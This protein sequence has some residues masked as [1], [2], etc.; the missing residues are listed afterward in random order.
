MRAVGR[1]KPPQILNIETC[2]STLQPRKTRG[3]IVSRG[4]QF[5][6]ATTL[7]A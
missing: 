1:S 7:D 5:E 4:E 2:A 3:S 6:T